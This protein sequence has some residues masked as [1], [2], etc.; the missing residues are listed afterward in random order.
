M[1]F[2]LSAIE[3]LALAPKIIA[4]LQL[5]GQIISLYKNSPVHAGDVAGATENVLDHYLEMMQDHKSG[6]EAENARND[7]S[8]PG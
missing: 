5:V 6:I 4:A 7:T 8:D 3:L 1:I 2:G